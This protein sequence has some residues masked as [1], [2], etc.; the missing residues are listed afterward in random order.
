MYKYLFYNPKD[1]QVEKFLKEQTFKVNF[2]CSFESCL[3]IQ[4]LKSEKVPIGEVHFTNNMKEY[5]K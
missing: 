2:P 4:A 5:E 3:G 1:N